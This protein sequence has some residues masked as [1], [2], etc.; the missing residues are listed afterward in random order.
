MRNTRFFSLLLP[1]LILAVCSPIF[2]SPTISLSP[3]SLTANMSGVCSGNP[4]TQ[5]VTISNS[6]GG[7]LATPSVSY[8]YNQGSGW[9][10]ATVS[11]SSAPY[12]LQVTFQN[13]CGLALGTYTATLGISSS[14]ATNSPVNLPITLNVGSS[15]SSPTISLS[16]NS[17]SFG[18]TAEGSNPAAQNVTVSNSGGGT[19]ASPTTSIS[20]GSGSGW[21]SVSCSGSPAPYTCSTQ[22]STGSLAAGTYT[23]TVNVSSS[24]A[25]NSPQ[26]YTVSFI[27]NSS[28]YPTISLSPTSLT[29]NMSGVCSGNPATQ[30]VTIS[31]S[32][33]GTLATPSVSYTYN[34]GSGWLN[35][36]VSGSSAPY[37]LQ[38]V[39][40]NTCSLA[41][42]TY[43]ATLGISSS[44][45]TNSP[46]N[47]PIT[48]NVGSSGSSPTISLSPNSLSFSATAEGSNP[49]AQNVTVSNSGGG[50]LASPTTSISYGSG[51][52]WLSVSCSGEPRPP[53]RVPPSRLGASRPGLTPPL[54]TYRVR[55]D[56]LASELCCL[57]YRQF[58]V[59]SDHLAFPNQPQL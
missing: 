20:Y 17:L 54:L 56:Q 16:T 51:S 13:T 57:V 8:T 10:N 50:T 26:S 35:A 52:G 30:Y 25:T 58:A 27:V 3:T 45:A 59:V 21:L 12:T 9:L 40:Q 22:P 41:E 49:A 19:L 36:T 43:T 2:G 32:G 5:N 33:G 24:G 34:Q 7:T 53:I 14:G 42:G 11:G 46:V 31:N 29:A 6:G 39:Y 4:A 37:T 15:G 1:L 44:G 47:L 28:P 38:V 55:S 23:A 48:L 18:A